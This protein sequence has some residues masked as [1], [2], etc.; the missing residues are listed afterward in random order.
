MDVRDV[1]VVGLDEAV[2]EGECAIGL[3]AGHLD[4]ER[5][6]TGEPYDTSVLAHDEAVG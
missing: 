3:L 5:F 1:A 6:V 2:H 4:R